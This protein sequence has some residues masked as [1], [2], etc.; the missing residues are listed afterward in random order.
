LIDALSIFRT[1]LERNT[2]LPQTC[3]YR[4]ADHR[5]SLR[6]P[7]ACLQLPESPWNNHV[8]ARVIIM[9]NRSDA[10]SGQWKRAAVVSVILAITAAT[11]VRLGAVAT[12]QGVDAGTERAERLK[13]MEVLARSVAVI[14]VANAGGGRTPVAMRPKPLHRWNEPTRR[15]HDGTLWAWGREGRPLVLFSL[16]QYPH[17]SFGLVWSYELVSLSDGLVAATGARGFARLTADYLNVEGDGLLPWTTQ[18][19]GVTMRPFP[20]AP[21]PGSTDGE[22]LRQ[23]KDLTRRLSACQFDGQGRQRAELRLLPHP[24]DRYSDPN[25]GLIDGAIFLFAYGT[26]PEVV[27]LIETRSEKQS[28]LRWEYGLTRLTGGRPSVSLDQK[29]VWCPIPVGGVAPDNSYISRVLL[30]KGALFPGRRP[31]G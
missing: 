4:I 19:P 24:I 11:P 23:I 14:E 8:I 17:P 2:W 5:A 3:S 27:L 12:S 6:T 29:E 1:L 10:T 18:N 16:E 20:G 30:P 25:S 7:G 9:Y 22:R 26:N 15:S 28:A 31:P 21:K 13:E